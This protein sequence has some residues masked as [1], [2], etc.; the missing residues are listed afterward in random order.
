MVMH[1]FSAIVLLLVVA[2]ASVQ[3]VSRARGRSSEQ[4]HRCGFMDWILVSGGQVNGVE[5]AEWGHGGHRGVQT[6]RAV[7]AGE[8]LVSLPPHLLMSVEDLQVKLQP[9]SHSRGNMGFNS[10][11]FSIHNRSTEPRINEIIDLALWL[12]LEASLEDSRW[13]PYLCMSRVKESIPSEDSAALSVMTA[14]CTDRVNRTNKETVQRRKTDCSLAHGLHSCSDMSRQRAEA[15]QEV[16][17]A[18]RLYM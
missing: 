6:T 7:R 16:A 9:F 15:V 8:V 12:T 4:E 2:M 5:I 13:G 14:D 1:E 18:V 17:N 10:K 3:G 11:R